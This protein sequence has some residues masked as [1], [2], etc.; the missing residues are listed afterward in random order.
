MESAA[1]IGRVYRMSLWFRGFALVFLIIGSFLSI[2]FLWEIQTGETDPDTIKTIIEIVFPIAG[3]AMTA[4]SFVSRVAFENNLL[5]RVTLVRQRT[6]SLHSIRGRREYVVTGGSEPG[7]TRY[8]RLELNNGEPP[9]DLG[10]KLYNFDE[11]FWAWFRSLPDLD[12]ADKI[13]Q[14]DSNF[15]LV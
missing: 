12:A 15:G 4:H 14:K 9:V 2:A 8:V 6:V 11:A 7:S 3:L 5:R 13:Q 1:P 10:K